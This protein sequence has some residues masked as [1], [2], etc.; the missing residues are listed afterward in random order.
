MPNRN[1]NRGRN[2]EYEIVNL[3]KEAGYD[4]Q[5]TAGSHGVFDIIVTKTD[6]ENQRIC[7][8]VLIQCKIKKK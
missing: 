2:Y 1:Y 5:R 7:Y 6:E 3:F 8:L 4:A